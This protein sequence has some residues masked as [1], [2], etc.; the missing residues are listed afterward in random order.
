ML[1]LLRKWLLLAFCVPTTVLL[2]QSPVILEPLMQFE[3]PPWHRVSPWLEGSIATGIPLLLVHLLLRRREQQLRQTLQHRLI[4][5]AKA[6]PLGF[7]LGIGLIAVI[8][9]TGYLARDIHPLVL[10]GAGLALAASLF[11]CWKMTVQLTR[12][13]KVLYMD[14][15]GITFLEKGFTPWSAVVGI[16][17]TWTIGQPLT[18]FGVLYLAVLDDPS[19]LHAAGRHGDGPAEGATHRPVSVRIVSMSLLLVDIHPDLAY[20]AAVFLHKKHGGPL[21]QDWSGWVTRR[22]TAAMV[23]EQ[24]LRAPGRPTQ[25][26]TAAAL[27]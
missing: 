17:L 22:Q 7:L 9:L 26:D 5:D 23:Q 18:R 20:E 10:P 21:L 13:Q 14:T 8:V 27:P 3:A 4:L 12:P 2:V 15:K 6:G 25:A 11:A 19:V 1:L 24:L 16:D